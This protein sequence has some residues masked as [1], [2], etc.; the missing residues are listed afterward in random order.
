MNKV[1]LGAGISGLGAWYA[2]NTAEIY[3]A[4][5][6]AGGLCRGF[7]INGFYFDQA[8][9]FSFAKDKIVR[10]VFD[11]IEQYYHHLQLQYQFQSVFLFLGQ[12]PTIFPVN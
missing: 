12:F 6:R 3:E 5:D 11:K 9:H 4:S 1:I 7:E 2:D 8:V 10:D